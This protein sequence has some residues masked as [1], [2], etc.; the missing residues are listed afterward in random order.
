MSRPRHVLPSNHLDSIRDNGSHEGQGDQG[1]EETPRPETRPF[2]IKDS[3]QNHDLI[4]PSRFCKNGIEPALLHKIGDR[5]DLLGPSIEVILNLH[6]LMPL[7][8]NNNLPQGNHSG[9]AI[10]VSR[11]GNNRSRPRGNNTSRRN[12]RI[13]ITSNF[14][15][16]KDKFIVELV[17][18]CDDAMMIINKTSGVFHNANLS[19]EKVWDYESFWISNM[20]DF[21]HSQIKLKLESLNKIANEMK[22]SVSKGAGK[23]LIN[24][25][26]QVPGGESIIDMVKTL[27]E[28]FE[29]SSDI[30]AADVE[31]LIK[32]LNFDAKSACGRALKMFE[33]E[34]KPTY[35]F[36]NVLIAIKAHYFNEA[37]S[38]FIAKFACMLVS[39]IQKLISL[40]V[41]GG[42]KNFFS[43]TE[44]DCHLDH[45]SKS[46]YVLFKKEVKPVP[47]LE[48]CP[49]TIQTEEENS[50][51]NARWEAVRIALSGEN[52]TTGTFRALA[53]IETS[54]QNKKVIQA[55]ELAKKRQMDLKG[56]PSQQ[57][58][59]AIKESDMVVKQV[60]K[61]FLDSAKFNQ[62][63]LKKFIEFVD[64]EDPTDFDDLADDLESVNK[65]LKVKTVWEEHVK[66]LKGIRE[67]GH[68]NKRTRRVYTALQNFFES[69]MAYITNRENLFNDYTD[70]MIQTT[71]ELVVAKK[72]AVLGLNA[73][74]CSLSTPEFAMIGLVLADAFK[75]DW[76]RIGFWAGFSA[77]LIPLVIC[78]YSFMRMWQAIS[79]ARSRK[80]L[81]VQFHSP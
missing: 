80:L 7:L 77:G 60:S 65:V 46:G 61:L 81:G 20:I 45:I 55:V 58:E 76:G 22:E 73:V 71:R 27:P 62:R 19:N 9:T 51:L 41:L 35:E 50:E 2:F 31:Y 6:Q 18:K 29:L 12:P 24:E 36:L 30:F 21:N 56:T 11:E 38:F 72:Y 79:R 34:E 44:M 53:G 33:L 28:V 68:V 78:L 49:L 3:S 47:Q 25:L 32:S 5:H 48:L 52:E 42:P 8:S 26:S 10:A 40:R 66:K 15:A 54:E 57:D 70:A 1:T 67:A 4:Y 16:A 37:F 63:A 13:L 74:F 17:G 43:R 39:N 75:L 64:L 69:E 14:T 23:A 59:A